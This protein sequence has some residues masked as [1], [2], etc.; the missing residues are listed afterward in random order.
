MIQRRVLKTQLVKSACFQGG[1]KLKIK[2]L[3]GAT[4]IRSDRKDERGFAFDD[5]PRS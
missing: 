4:L 5:L 2:R 3:S 1:R